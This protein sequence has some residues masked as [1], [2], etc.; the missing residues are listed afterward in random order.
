[1]GHSG[2]FHTG[3]ADGGQIDRSSVLRRPKAAAGAGRT[4]VVVAYEP[5]QNLVDQPSAVFAAG[6]P[7][8]ATLL[9]PKE[10]RPTHQ[11]TVAGASPV[12]MRSFS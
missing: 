7:A 4:G 9:L 1:M 11:T 6:M 10:V 2:L 3:H 8:L 12:T 5:P